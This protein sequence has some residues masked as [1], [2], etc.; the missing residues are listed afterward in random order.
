MITSQPFDLRLEKVG[1]GTKGGKAK[2]VVTLMG[3]GGAMILT[4]YKGVEINI[5]PTKFDLLHRAVP[6]LGEHA[7]HIVGPLLAIASGFSIAIVLI[8]ALIAM[9]GSLQ[10]IVYAPCMERDWSQWKL[11]RDIRLFTVA[12]LLPQY[13][14]L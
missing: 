13:V 12:W 10:G 14:V 2:V 1:L 6:P 3:I 5:W 11:G 4:F 8:T 9:M 7:S